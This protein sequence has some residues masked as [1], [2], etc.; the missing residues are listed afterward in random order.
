L[1]TRHVAFFI[2]AA[3]LAQAVGRRI[4]V[5]DTGEPK[6]AVRQLLANTQNSQI[7][8]PGQQGNT[9]LALQRVVNSQIAR[10]QATLRDLEHD[11][12]ELEAQYAMPSDMF[13]ARWSAGD[14][15]DSA[16]SMDWHVL[17]EM[18]AEARERVG[19]LKGEQWQPT[20][21]WSVFILNSS[22][23]RS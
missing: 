9:P 14:L 10:D 17:D 16:D 18:V 8:K 13:H 15:D 21:T 7:Q 22:K 6:Q 4:L 12:A 20:S 1:L 19:L 3:R 23:T 11:L 5:P 2:I